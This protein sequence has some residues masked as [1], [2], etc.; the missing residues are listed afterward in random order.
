MKYSTYILTTFETEIEKE[1]SSK[2]DMMN[3]FL[4]Y[5][6][7]QIKELLYNLPFTMI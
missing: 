7:K 3:Y 6:E 4:V 1:F 2:K 5:I